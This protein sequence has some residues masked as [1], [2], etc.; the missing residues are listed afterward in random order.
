[1]Q[2]ELSDLGTLGALPHHAP[3]A[4]AWG[5]GVKPRNCLRR[6]RAR[7]E[8]LYEEYSKA[9]DASDDAAQLSPGFL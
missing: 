1:M 2:A 9:A 6:R 8:D 5:K 4:P 3:Q 7:L